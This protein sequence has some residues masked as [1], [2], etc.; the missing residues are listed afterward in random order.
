MPPPS[1]RIATVDALRGIASLSV[2]WFHFTNS[3][4]ALTPG[5]VKSSGNYGWLGVYIFFVIS[6]FVIPYSLEKANYGYRQFW[7]FLSKRIV[8]LDPP[9]FANMVFILGLAF[10]VPLVP[11]F[12]GPQPHFTATQLA[13]HF[14]YL[15]SVFGKTWINPV[16]WSLGIE[17]QYYLLIGLIFPLLCSSRV[18]TRMLTMFALLVP[19]LFVRGGALVFSHL[20]L[21]LAGILTYQFKVGRLS[22][23]CY[24]GALAVTAMV[25]GLG[26]GLVIAVTCAITSLVI[27]FVE[28]GGTK[29]TWLGSISY[30]LYL[31]H[32]PVGGKIV[33]IGTRFPHGQFVPSLFLIAASAASIFAAWVLYR[34]V[35]LPSQR[36]SSRISYGKSRETQAE[37]A[38]G[39]RVAA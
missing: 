11:G 6:G 33:N 25:A 10:V 39:C 31:M 36:L 29:L 5:I 3:N 1:G 24:F 13:S 27:A 38:L 19:G 2:A 8:R 20:P 30:S 17:F 18:A 23:G 28:F 16:Y 12:R 34:L 35:E 26:L 7:M 14:A 22:K 4:P 15:N 37:D 21:F 32:V 9:Y